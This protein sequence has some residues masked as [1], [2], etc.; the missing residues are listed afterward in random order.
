MSICPHLRRPETLHP[1][2]LELQTFVSLC[3][4]GGNQTQI[5]LKSEQPVLNSEQLLSP[6][7]TCPALPC[8]DYVT[9]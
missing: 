4:G 3:V 1:L 7:S 6:Y 8:T 5:L 2:G 9:P